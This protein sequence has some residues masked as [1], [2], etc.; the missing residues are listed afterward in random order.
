MVLMKLGLGLPN[1]SVFIRILQ[2][3]IGEVVVEHICRFF[4]GASHQFCIVKN[5]LLR[6][7]DASPGGL[8]R[9]FQNSL[10]KETDKMTSRLL[11][12]SLL[13]WKGSASSSRVRKR[14]GK[15]NFQ[16][17]EQ[18][19]V[20]WMRQCRGQN[21]PMGG[22][23]LKEK[24]KAFAKE[25]GIVLLASEGW[26]TNF[27]K[28]NGI[29][30]KKM[31][32][33]SSTLPEQ[34]LTFDDYVLVDTD[35]AVWGALSDAEIVTLDHNNTES[36]EDESEELTPVTLGRQPLARGPHVARYTTRQIWEFLSGWKSK[37]LY[38]GSYLTNTFRVM[39][40]NGIAKESEK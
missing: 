18:C 29:V 32:G 39:D 28:R 15:G 9:A 16:R 25:L 11:H 35:I 21:I 2:W 8:L 19:L 13:G 36:D 4:I 3:D 12:L 34:D 20:S 14:V 38:N 5:R 17:L 22:S 10:P 30:F 33:E 1:R 40:I 31:C 26:L 24:A 23:L 7:F 6:W 37:N 27:K